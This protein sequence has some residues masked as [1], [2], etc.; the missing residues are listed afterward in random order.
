M[1]VYEA[2]SQ[3]FLA[4]AGRPLRSVTVGEVQ[5]YRAT[6]EHLAPASRARKLSAVK[7]LLSFARR[8]GYVPFDV[9]SVVK[10]PPIKNK[11]AERI[12][13][14]RQRQRCGC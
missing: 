14:D 2:D 12:I 5:S 8:L 9:G 6:L 4:H 10:L 11:L 3:A 1:W 7:S 13:S